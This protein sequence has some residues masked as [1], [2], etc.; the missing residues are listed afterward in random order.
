MAVND[1]VAKKSAGYIWVL[2]VTEFVASG[3]QCKW[4]LTETSRPPSLDR[5]SSLHVDQYPPAVYLLTVRMFVRSWNVTQIST[6]RRRIHGHLVCTHTIAL[7][8][9]VYVPVRL[10]NQ[11]YHK[12][13]VTFLV[14]P[15]MSVPTNFTWFGSFSWWPC[16]T[17]QHSQLTSEKLFD[18]VTKLKAAASIVVAAVTVLL[19]HCEIK[20]ITW[21]T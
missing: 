2:I 15:Q 5:A 12:L 13:L 1:I 3:N 8:C 21:V 11:K 19:F 7:P 10:Y 14:F 16:C 20:T 6:M 9:T 18:Y 17:H 4:I